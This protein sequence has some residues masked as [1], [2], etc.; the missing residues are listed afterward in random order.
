MQTADE[1]AS[2]K[3]LLQV[4]VDALRQ[5][6]VNVKE[7]LTEQ[8]VC[9]ALTQSVYAPHIPS[10]P[11]TEKYLCG[12]C[13]HQLGHR[14]ACTPTSCIQSCSAVLHVSLCAFSPALQFALSACMLAVALLVALSACMLQV[15]SAVLHGNGKLSMLLCS[16]PCQLA[17]LAVPNIML[18]GNG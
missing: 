18:E 13:V 10:F 15:C 1:L 17:L 8:Q 6:V 2:Q 3:D 4:E 11:Q 14:V 16:Y 7:Q 12:C 9:L 5:E